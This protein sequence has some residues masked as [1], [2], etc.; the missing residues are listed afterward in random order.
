MQ[1][2]LETLGVVAI[3]QALWR[4]VETGSAQAARTGS[5]FDPPSSVVAHRGGGVE[6]FMTHYGIEAADRLS[7]LYIFL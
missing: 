5:I 4:L 1:E 6:Y 2:T 3:K 7:L